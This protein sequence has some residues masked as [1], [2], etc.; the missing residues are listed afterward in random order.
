MSI[1]TTLRTG[2]PDTITLIQQIVEDLSDHGFNVI[3]PSNYVPTDRPTLTTLTVVVQSTP[4]VDA[5]ANTQP[6]TITFHATNASLLQLFVAT[7]LQM[8]ANGLPSRVSNLMDGSGSA[9]N[10][11]YYAGET[12]NRSYTAASS[13][14]DL[15]D[16]PSFWFINRF[17][18]N[19]AMPMNYRLTVT[20]HG[21]FIGVYEGNWSSMIDATLPFTNYFNWVLV[22]RPVNKETGSVLLTGK[23][24]VFA[25]SCTNNTYRR[26][27]VR[28]ADIPHPTP[29]I[30][31]DTMSE[32]G[33]KVINSKIQ[34][35]VTENKKYIVSFLGNLNTP[36][37]R[38]VEELDMVATISADVVSESTEITL[39]V[40][41][42]NRIYTAMPCNL[43]YNTGMRLLVLTGVAPA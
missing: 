19:A 17:S 13:I 8:T 5:L 7:P 34:N 28:E 10:T 14:N 20:D 27:V 43:P 24:P 30:L 21:V 9:N 37:F 15:D 11:L 33:F 16:N 39:N 38:Y 23:C 6:W 26:F 40:Y 35:S 4:D 42:E 25:L 41:G 12:A 22:Q 3:Y 2:F 32:D 36:R 29:S 18:K 1:F 31:A